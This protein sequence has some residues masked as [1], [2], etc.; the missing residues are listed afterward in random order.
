MNT[1]ARSSG[2]KTWS[3]T[4]SLLIVARKD[5]ACQVF[6]MRTP[7]S[8]SGPGWALVCWSTLHLGNK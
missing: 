7:S 4:T 5:M 3:S 8:S 2:K 1:A 6:S